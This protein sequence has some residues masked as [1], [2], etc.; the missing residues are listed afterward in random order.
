MTTLGMLLFDTGVLVFLL[1]RLEARRSSTA[2]T[3]R[4]ACVIAG[5]F[6]LAIATLWIDCTPQGALV[7][8]ASVAMASI[9]YRGEA[10]LRLGEAFGRWRFLAYLAAVATA[11]AL[12][13]VVLP[14]MTLL[15]SPGELG[16]HV[17]YLLRSAAR[18]AMVIVYLAAAFYA[19]ALSSR[20]KT[21]LALAAIGALSVALLYAF[22]LPF[23]YPRMTGLM[24]EQVPV[25]LGSR[26]LRVIADGVVLIAVG[27]T[28]R[29]ALLRFGI[30]PILVGMG[31]VNV[32][33]ALAVGVGV[34]RDA[35][36]GAGD[37]ASDSLPER[38]PIQ[39]APNKPNALLI[40]LDRFMGSYV[41]AILES[42]PDIQQRLSGFVWYPRTVSAGENSIAGIHPM[43]G[44]YDYTP[45]A[46]NA[47]GAP[48]VEQSIEAFS[49]LPLN[50]S[51]KGYQ[52]NVVN[53]GGL[54]FTM[55]GDCS[56]LEGPVVFCSHIPKSVVKQR[57]KAMG[58]PL[59]ELSKSSYADLLTLLS[60]MRALPYLLKDV[61][62]LRGPWKPFLDHGAGTTFKIWAELNSF[63]DLSFTAASQSNL[64]IVSNLLP[65]EPYFLGE[66]CLP[67]LTRFTVAEEEL[68]RRG[69]P[70]LFSMQHAIAAR[71]T[72]LAVADYL[73]FLKSKG[74][75]DQTRIVIVSDHGIV[76]PVEDR[77]RR[78]VAGGTTQNAFVRTRSVLLVKVR[79]ATGPL[80]ISENFMPN[81]EVPR[82]LCEEIQGCVNPFLRDTPIETRGRDDPFFVSLV[83]WQFSLQHRNAFVI[84]QQFVLR[85]KDPFD[86][87]GW[88]EVPR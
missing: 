15:T 38:L 67:R 77:S 47:R 53:P 14:V 76:G 8:I 86:V 19:L 72:L 66:D 52:V 73:D 71:C 79:G 31:L 7:V 87:S 34:T 83:P 50:F 54:G 65:H 42:D 48:L 9:V 11:S 29:S 32:S 43:L 12:V 39:F 80:S 81:A 28:I 37:D 21:I 70:N 33:L 40:F 62:H 74:V 58:F 10:L 30:R 25:S 78:A 68:Q 56:Y 26:A 45:V 84:R 63:P 5:M 51:K 55:T 4:I 27:L 16:I 22:V 60:T 75:Y 44:G 36:G 2:R 20:M 23:G 59:S 57:A 64:N 82:I 85:G 18:D 17:D 3:T 41:E 24:F 88:Q 69:Y 49:I 46:M 61:V 13:F 35:V 1:R 6:A